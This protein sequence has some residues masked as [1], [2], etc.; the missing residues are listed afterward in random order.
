MLHRLTE[1]AKQ[2]INF[3]RHIAFDYG[4]SKI[5]PEHLTLGIMRVKVSVVTK[6]L[7]S[8]HIDPAQV[9]EEIDFLSLSRSHI[10]TRIDE[11]S[12]SSVSNKVLNFAEEEADALASPVVGIE[13]ILMGILRLKNSVAAEVLNSYGLTLERITR[14]II[15]GFPDEEFEPFPS[16]LDDFGVDLVSLARKG[17]LDPLIGRERELALLINVLARRKKN[18]PLLV[19]EPGVGKTAIVEGFAQ[20][21]ASGKVP[22][23]AK[24]K[25]I[26]MLSIP[27]VVAGTRYR[28]DF[29]ERMRDIID[30]IEDRE[31]TILFIDE[32]HSI[33]G[34]G[35]A[36]GSID[37][38]SILK[39]FLTEGKI[40]VIGATI[41][42]DYRK[43]LEQDP[44][45][46][47]RF[48]KI[49]VDPPDKEEV[50]KILSGI[51]WKY[52][53]HHRVKYTKEA[54]KSIILLSQVYI[55]DRYFPDKAVD[56]LDEVGAKVR[57]SD[58][59]TV[60][61]NDVELLVSLKTGIP[62]PSIKEGEK[63]KIEKLRERL[64]SKVIGQGGAINLLVSAIKRQRVG[65]RRGNRPWG[66]FLFVG[67][68]GVGKTHTARMLAKYLMG[69]ED[70]LIKMDMSEFKEEHSISKLIGAP[71]GYVGYGEGGYLTEK[72]RNKPYS[73]VLLD[74][75]EKAHPSLFHVFLQVF[76]DGKLTD[77][78]S[79]TAD[80]SNTIIIMTSN[81]GTKEM[82]EKK[83][84]GFASLSQLERKKI[85]GEEMKRF[86]PP[87]FLNR[88][89][90]IVF[91]GELGEKE[92]EKI[93]KLQ[94]DE[95][96]SE[97][98]Q[99]RW[100]IKLDKSA[101]KY[102]AKQ[103]LKQRYFGARPVRRIIEREILDRASNLILNKGTK[104]VIIKI[105]EENGRLVVEKG[106]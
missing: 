56:I 15:K 61:K 95:V 93:V 104:R 91:F 12:L 47:R 68:T 86:F 27:Q 53:E 48:Q 41:P 16:V 43:Y 77:S 13:H 10:R 84:I 80:F 92:L 97:S 23:F 78:M 106:N 75:I 65:I 2:V 36:E 73:I 99:Y 34:A 14:F 22:D 44:A 102:I 24:D 38:S 5:E 79:R 28:G 19:G 20:R 55:S 49:V 50:F 6:I 85:I 62:L 9:K 103:A 105:H 64:F 31:D 42:Q 101:T 1:G 21:I 46:E 100:S 4:H 18:N 25:T 52:E 63:E 58:R 66:V 51:K 11:I 96:N 8:F 87:E 90:E 60:R 74:E 69:N 94:V 32:L 57:L 88:I 72:V 70:R 7:N 89:D 33:V 37:A 67:P 54:I 45:L 35:A 82:G 3:A 39:P 59:K 40:R 29:E 83:K 26:I 76:E 17:K 30:E 98:S 71:P 81:I